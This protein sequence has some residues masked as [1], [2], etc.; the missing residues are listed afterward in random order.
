[1]TVDIFGI[2]HETPDTKG[3]GTPVVC[4]HCGSV[5]D[6]QAVTVTA[7]YSDCSVFITP[8]CNRRADDRSWVGSPSFTRL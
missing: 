8:C 3:M 6:L 4:S 7:R 1:M 5:Y 2:V